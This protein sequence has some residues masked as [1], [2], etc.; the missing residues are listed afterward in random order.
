LREAALGGDIAL[1]NHRQRYGTARSAADLTS[2]ELGAPPAFLD[3]AG[4]AAWQRIG[5]TVPAGLLCTMDRDLVAALAAAIVRHERAVTV[6][7]N[8][9]K[10]D[11]AIVAESTL[12]FNIERHMHRTARQVAALATA[13]GL[14][15]PAR[16]RLAV[17]YP[18]V[19][20]S[21]DAPRF[22]KFDTLLPDG[23]VVRYRAPGGSRKTR[24]TS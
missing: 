16:S 10:R 11:G 1:R 12:F 2:S 21:R 20:E 5:A 15:P 24:L 13:L 23:K 7:Q 22:Q 17:P 6:S 19:V 14:S 8:A 9:W 4:K 18:P 3:T